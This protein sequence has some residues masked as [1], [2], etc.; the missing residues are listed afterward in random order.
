M[1]KRVL[2]LLGTAILTVACTNNPKSI[3]NTPQA[4]AEATLS[5]QETQQQAN[6]T[7]EVVAWDGRWSGVIP[8]ASC[9]GIEV[10]LT[11][12]NDGTFRLREEYLEQAGDPVVTK[13]TLSWDEETGILTLRSTDREQ[14]LLFKGMGEAI[15]LDAEGKTAPHYRLIKQAE[16]RAPGQQ[17]IL[18]LQSVRVEADKVYFSGLLNFSE[19]QEG[20][21]K[22]VKG[23]AMI[24]C[25]TKQVTFRDAAYYPDVDAIG[26]RIASVSHMV[27]G[28]FRLEGSSEDSVLLQLADTFCPATS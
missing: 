25:K 1:K 14:R 16:Y 13:G 5:T 21:F 11:F 27:Q 12:N 20:A 2:F 22:S 18:P 17:L 8:C 3:D 10:D 26:Q 7:P 15:Y 19:A 24:D 4:D 28:G 6:P 9:P 23:D